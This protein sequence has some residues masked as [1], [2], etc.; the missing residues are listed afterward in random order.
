[1]QDNIAALMQSCHVTSHSPKKIATHHPQILLPKWG[2]PY[3]HQCQ[4][5]AGDNSGLQLSRPVPAL[6]APFWHETPV[7]NPVPVWGAPY[8][9][10]ASMGTRTSQFQHWASQFQ[11]WASDYLGPNIYNVEDAPN[12]RPH[13]GLEYF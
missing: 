7:L 9:H 12:S 5:G 1:M 2:A 10:G 13:Y 8:W 11:H 4:Y 3:W 6:G